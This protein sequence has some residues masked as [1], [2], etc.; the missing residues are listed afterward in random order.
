MMPVPAGTWRWETI[1]PFET[2]PRTRL[3]LRCHAPPEAACRFGQPHLLRR[4][5]P[6]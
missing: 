5:G 1:G 2:G 4:D 3:V 6:Y